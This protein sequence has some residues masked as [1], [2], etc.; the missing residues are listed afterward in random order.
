LKLFNQ[1]SL[2][3]L[4]FDGRLTGINGAIADDANAWHGDWVMRMRFWS[5]ITRGDTDW[6]ANASDARLSPQS[7]VT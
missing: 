1:Y 4:A 2:K 5:E 7:P 3:C 6:C